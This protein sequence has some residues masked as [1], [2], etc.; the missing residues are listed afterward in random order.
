M[1]VLNGEKEGHCSTDD[2][3]ALNEATRLN[4]YAVN[5]P[6]Y[7]WLA[8]FKPFEGWAPPASLPKS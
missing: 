2:Y 8:P 1:R 5:C 6:I 3:V 7:P 4:E